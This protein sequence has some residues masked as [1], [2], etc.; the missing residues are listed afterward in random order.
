[1]GSKPQQMSDSHEKSDDLIAELA[2]LMA[3][4]AGGAETGPKPSVIKLPPLN[5]ATIKA[6][7]VRIP[8]ME[9]PQPAAESPR[10]APATIGAAP[11]IRIPGM[12]KPAGVDAIPAPQPRPVTQFDFG[13]P[14]APTAVPKPEPFQL[15]DLDAAQA[16]PA[17]PPRRRDAVGRDEVR[18]GEA[19]HG[20]P[21]KP[22]APSATPRP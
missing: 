1:M 21:P 19:D 14:P 20:R 3:N 16:S 8:G 7:P 15:A 17:P 5:E 12:E 6:T 2:K 13:K 10:P 22:V 9:A 4:N 11:T 18:S